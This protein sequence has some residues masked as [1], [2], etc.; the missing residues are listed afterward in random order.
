MIDTFARGRSPWIY[1]C[2]YCALLRCTNKCNTCGHSNPTYRT[3]RMWNQNWKK[4]KFL[5]IKFNLK[6]LFFRFEKPK[7]KKWH[8]KKENWPE[9]KSSHETNFGVGCPFENGSVCL[10]STHVKRQLWKEKGRWKEWKKRIILFSF[11]PFFIL[12]SFS[13]S[14]S[15][16]WNSLRHN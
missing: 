3:W 6:T 7:L 2:A 9:K 4:T 14:G 5:Q 13:G 1:L 16:K 11:S 10:N 8:F 12:Y 15:L